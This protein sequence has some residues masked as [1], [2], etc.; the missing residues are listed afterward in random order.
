MSVVAELTCR[1]GGNLHSRARLAHPAGAAQS[2]QPVIGQ[3]LVHVVDRCAA[4][5]E[6]S[7]LHWETMGGNVIGGPRRREI[8]AQVGVAQLHDPLRAARIAQ[9]LSSP[10]GQ[11]GIGREVV[12]DQ[13]ARKVLQPAKCGR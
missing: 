6:A 1:L 5:D 3:E 2:H 11:P 10:I 7:Q 8:I 13:I 4:P 9:R 12:D